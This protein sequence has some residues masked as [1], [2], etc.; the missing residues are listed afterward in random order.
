MRP[1]V[2]ISVDVEVTD[3]NL[4]FGKLLQVGAVTSQGEEI[5]LNFG[6]PNDCHVSHWVRENLPE[7]LH[8]AFV[9]WS[10]CAHMPTVGVDGGRHQVSAHTYGQAAGLQQWVNEQRSGAGTVPGPYVEGEVHRPDKPQAVFIAYCGG[11]DWSF[12][13]KLFSEC[14]LENPFNYE[15]IEI[16]S[17][18]MGKLGLPWGF[19]EAELEER[20]GVEPMGDDKHDALADAK[21]QLQ[22]FHKLMEI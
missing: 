18:A 5:C 15:F 7:L 3:T 19:T 8:Q 16:S 4:E 1:P 6:V 2:Y 10:M 21:H 17:L 13:S 12:V 9:M 14:D 22:L 20:L 11:L